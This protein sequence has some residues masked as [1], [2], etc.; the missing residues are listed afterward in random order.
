VRHQ[1]GAFIRE[2]AMQMKKVILGCSFLFL[3]A[4]CASEQEIRKDTSEMTD[5]LRTGPEAAPVRSVKN[6][7]KSKIK[8]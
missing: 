2:Y 1:A 6:N 5:K 8:K 4:G 3:M 7:V